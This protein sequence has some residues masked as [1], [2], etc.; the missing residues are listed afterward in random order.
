MEQDLTYIVKR[1]PDGWFDDVKAIAGVPQKWQA[2]AAAPINQYRW[3][4]P[5]GYRPQSFARAAYSSKGI[6]LYFVSFEDEIIVNNFDMQGKMYEDSCMEIFYKPLSRKSGSLR[7]CGN[8][9][10]GSGTHGLWVQPLRP[11]RASNSPCGYAF[12]RQRHPRDVKGL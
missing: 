11:H 1:V 9:R 12:D 8:Q 4:P 6:H 10:R 5:S 3:A 7:Q 2:F